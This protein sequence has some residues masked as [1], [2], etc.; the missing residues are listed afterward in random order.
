MQVFIVMIGTSS[1]YS[2][3]GTVWDVDRVF[4]TTEA[5][6]LYITQKNNTNYNSDV[7]YN[8]DIEEVY[9]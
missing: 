1:S 6:M 2:Y 3:D 4:A 7:E 8:I 9:A 5:A